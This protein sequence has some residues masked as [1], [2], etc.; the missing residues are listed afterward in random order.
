MRQIG[1][2][3]YMYAGENQGTLPWAG[4]NWPTGT[5]NSYPHPPAYLP[6]GINSFSISWDDLISPQL[7]HGFP[8]ADVADGYYGKSTTGV[9]CSV[10]LRATLPG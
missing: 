4:W 2:A 5:P 1:I 10:N 9:A 6:T 7:G 3:M 8:Y